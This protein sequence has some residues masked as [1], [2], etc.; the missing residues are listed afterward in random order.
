MPQGLVLPTYDQGYGISPQFVDPEFATDLLDELK[1]N[2]KYYEGTAGSGGLPGVRHDPDIV[3][4]LGNMPRLT[5]YR[6]SLN[7]AI[8]EA[9][10]VRRDH[11][12]YLTVRVC[13]V[14][15]MS[16][17]IHRNDRAAGPWLITLTVAG[18]GSFN[19]YEDNLL[20]PGQE[21]PLRGDG[22]D[23][24]PIASSRM[25]AGDAWS[26]YSRE[27]SAPHAGGPSTSLYPK[28]LVML[29]GWNVRGEYPFRYDKYPEDELPETSKES[30]EAIPL[31]TVE[32]V[33]PEKSAAR[34]LYEFAK[35]VAAE[36][37]SSGYQT[38]K[39]KIQTWRQKA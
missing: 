30:D 2:D 13:P 23:P 18:S 25:G 28:V 16:S 15:E 7:E 26:I 32:Q 27:R 17:D 37:V 11:L 31:Y 12:T 22:L 35:P 39:K 6:N 3:R 34:Q 9:T 14:A 36:L 10:G 4:S 21:I 24:S 19:I 8:I 1:E 29:Y 33:E 5:E 38:V 20:E